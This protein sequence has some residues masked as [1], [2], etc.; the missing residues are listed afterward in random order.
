MSEVSNCRCYASLFLPSVKNRK[1]FQIRLTLTTNVIVPDIVWQVEAA[2]V[3]RFHFNFRLT[4]L[5]FGVDIKAKKFRE[6]TD[7]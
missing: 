6:E 3:C 4:P 2:A 5:Y 7:F 1:I